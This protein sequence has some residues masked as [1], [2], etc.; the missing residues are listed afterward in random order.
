MDENTLLKKICEIFKMFAAYEKAKQELAEVTGISGDENIKYMYRQLK[1]KRESKNK[2]QEKTMYVL[3]KDCDFLGKN[4]E[5]CYLSHSINDLEGSKI[6]ITTSKGEVVIY[7][8]FN[9]LHEYVEKR[10]ELNKQPTKK[11]AMS[12]C[13]GEEFVV[14]KRCED[15]ICLGIYAECG[16]GEPCEKW[17]YNKEKIMKML[18]DQSNE[19]K[20]MEYK[21]IFKDAKVGDLVY[22]L[23][24]CYE[25]VKFYPKSKQQL[26]LRGVSNC[27]DY[28]SCDYRGFDLES[29]KQPSYFWQPFE[30]P[31]H[32][33]EKPRPEL[34]VDDP[35]MVSNDNVVWHK[36]RFAKWRAGFIFC[37]NLGAD[38][39]TAKE[40]ENGKKSAIWNFHRLP[41]KEELEG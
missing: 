39:W 37:W 32:A 11:K 16:N 20:T 10:N 25:I 41:T 36:R 9:L 33:F 40:A 2:Q 14:G 13:E 12:E 29:D 5:E 21:E 3:R 30:I 22:S 27:A 1:Q 18:N 26:E 7:N 35:V 6:T 38:S 19:E 17:N 34:K 24:G 31:A 4:G 28:K 15:C 8:D 23:R